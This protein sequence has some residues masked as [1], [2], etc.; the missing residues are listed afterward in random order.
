MAVPWYLWFARSPA[1]NLKGG[2]GWIRV[3]E[4]GMRALIII[5]AAVAGIVGL[6][7]L[8]L[9]IK[10]APFPAY[11]H[12]VTEMATVPLPAGLPAPVDRFF[13]RIY[14]ERVPLITSAVISG[15]ATL[16]PVLALPGLQSRFRFT[17]QAG[18]GYRHYIETTFFG[19]PL[20]RGNERYL[21][22]K[23]YLD[24]GPIGVSEGPNIDQAGNL[25]LWAESVWLPAIWVTDTR[26]RWAP[27]DDVTAV[28]VVPCGEGED[29][30]LLRFDPQT[31]MLRYLEAMRYREATDVAKRLWI[32]EALQWTAIDGYTLPAEGCITWFDQGT[33]WAVFN[34]EDVVYNADVQE[35]IGQTGS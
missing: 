2:E 4:D 16:R 3:W 20:I 24:L 18:Q 9:S 17:H 6:L 34:V 26:V 27:V 12:A 31:G 32:C 10:P 5:V 29:R 22:G 28:M 30:L 7:W 23:G 13:R 1:R 35:Y 11:P 19:L 15:R 33:A 25:G 14:G 21:G 8:G